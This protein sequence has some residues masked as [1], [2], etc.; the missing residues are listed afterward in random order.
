MLNNDNMITVH[1]E[2]HAPLDK[3]WEYWTLPEH[4][5]HWNFASDDWHCPEAKN[6]LI[7]GG[8]FTYRME[9]KDGSMGFDF[10]GTYTEIEERKFI[11]YKMSDGRKVMIN[12][13]I[14]GDRVTL[15]EAFEAE[16]SNSDELQRLGWQAI[17]VNFKTYV[18]Q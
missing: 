4:I 3:V 13:E 16:G 2:I 1:I 10:E 14:Q 11:A 15:S 5:V 17:L 12:F 8:T 7:S 6:D 9:A 18:E